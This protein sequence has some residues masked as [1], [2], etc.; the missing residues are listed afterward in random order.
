MIKKYKL[1]ECTEGAWKNGLGKTRQIAIF[2]AEATLAEE[3][4]DWRLSSATVLG[5][6]TFSQFKGCDRWLIVWKGE[7]LILNGKKLLPHS[8]LHFNGEESVKCSL[9]KDEVVD[10]GLIY[11]RTKIKAI[12]S[13]VKGPIELNAVQQTSVLFLE[14]GEI[15]IVQNERFILQREPNALAYQFLIEHL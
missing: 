8:P 7:G 15:I 9:I 4:F 10:V 6:N 3:N 13:V 11:N 2:P 14:E 1:S 5:E 12:L